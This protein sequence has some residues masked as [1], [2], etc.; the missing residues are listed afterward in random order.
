MTATEHDRRRLDSLLVRLA[1][2]ELR[3][4]P[5][6][7]RPILAVAQQALCDEIHA[8]VRR[9]DASDYWRRPRA[10]TACRASA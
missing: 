9:H 1:A 2:L 8:L 6:H 4:V 3:L 7:E 10:A 5:P